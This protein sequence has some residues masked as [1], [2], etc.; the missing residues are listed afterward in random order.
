MDLPPPTV[1]QFDEKDRTR[2]TL[3]GT[4]EIYDM[5]TA[6]VQRRL[7]DAKA[8]HEIKD[9]TTTR[10]SMDAAANV[11]HI[12]NLMDRETARRVRD[13]LTTHPTLDEDPDTVDGMTTYEIFIDSPDLSSSSNV[14]RDDNTIK[15]LNVQ[16]ATERATFRRGMQSILR[17]ILEHRITPLVRYLYGDED[18]ACGSH[19][20][21]RACT[22]CYSL[23]RRYR[24]EDR[25]SHA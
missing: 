15:V 20:P 5:A 10:S 9:S 19:D 23:I 13:V 17:P 18:D 6:R 22:P 4:H 12:A 8:D 14:V 2:L 3:P 21:H 1:F 11:T 16:D 7:L 25:V 24:T